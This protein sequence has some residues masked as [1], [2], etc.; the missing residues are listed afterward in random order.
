M[1]GKLDR[2]ALPAPDYGVLAGE[3][4]AP[5]SVA[6]EILCG[7]FADVLGLDVV[8]PEGDFFELGGHSLLAVRLA[9]R[10][11]VLLGVEIPVR[12]VFAAPTPAGLAAWLAQAAPARLRL[13]P[14]GRP[15]RVPLSFAQQ[16]LWFIAQLEGPSA[17]YNNPVALRLEGDLDAA[18]LEAALGD[19]LAR[20]EVLRTVFPSDHGDPFQ[21]VLDLA[22]L[23]WALPVTEVAEEELAGMI[24]E[25]A[26]VPFDLTTEVPVRLRLLA[27]GPGVHVL[28]VVIHH[29]ATDGWSTG[30]LARDIST[31]Y[32]ARL[33]GREPDW[34]PLPVQYA[35]YAI[36]QR[37]LL[38][39]EDDPASLLA[40]QV[41]WWRHA[42]DGAPPELALPADHPRPPMPS[43]RGH[44]VPLAIPAEVHARLAELDSRAGRDDV[45]G[46]PGRPRG[47]AV[48]ARGG[49][50][51]PVGTAVAG[52]ADEAVDDLVGFFVNTLVLRT[53]VSGDP[54]FTDV[55]ARVREYWLAAL[56]HQDVPFERLVEALA[57]ERSLARHALFQVMLTVQNNTSAAIALPGQRAARMPTGKPTARFDLQVSLG[58]AR[59]DQGLPAGL[60]G[61][62]VAAADLFDEATARAL[63]GRFAAVLAAVTASPRIPL[64]E[65]AVLAVA[66]R[67]QLLAGWNDTA[68]GVPAGSL[69]GLILDRAAAAPDAVAVVCG[70][71]S[72][73]YGE[74][75]A[76][77]SRL[78]WLLR[79]RGAGPESVVGVCLERGPGMVA[80]VV[81]AWLAGAGYVPLDP[82]YPAER[83]AFMLADSGAGLVVTSGSVAGGL[84]AVSAGVVCLDDPVT[85]AELAGLPSVPPPGE[86]DAGQLA[87]VIYTSGSTGRPNGVAVGQGS[88]VNMAAALSPALDARP[89]SRML[90]FAS[91]SFDAS[92]L[93]VA[94]SLTSGCTLVI[95]SAAERSDPAVLAGLVEQT[96]MPD[97]E[98]GA[99]AAGGHGPG[100]DGSGRE[101]DRGVGAAAGAAGGGVVGGTAADSRLR[102]DRGD[103]DHGHG[104][105]GRRWRSAADRDADGQLAGVRAGPVAGAGPGGGGRGAVPG[106]GAAGPGL[107]GPAGAD[108]VE[109]RGLPV[110]GRGADVPDG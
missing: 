53:D 7:A 1:N 76:R 43:H 110:R 49:E 54:A 71:G 23:G 81:A 9:S 83:L 98:R 74:L 109:V 16:R 5:Q 35:D 14:Q 80:A 87:Y 33:Q 88:V 89:G 11:R 18:A 29:V 103:G 51:I 42:L 26:A 25:T 102:A 13:V 106:R 47:P 21:H 97:R 72:V 60:G 39:D 58:E 17:V 101:H 56:D 91:F 44:V 92:V 46:H 82:G 48:Q 105:D 6:E 32:A 93:D 64:R 70:C 104:A 22:E 67:V 45:H 84:G 40:A 24:A 108:R 96:G 52:R 31:A 8:G 75:V 3:A 90:Q 20:H 100:P 41:A 77:A 50:D 73:S 62:L 19:V 55:L 10:V 65:V 36:W 34:A 37:D 107:R 95:A 2:R 79:G 78:A 61:S 68:R 38:G 86:P 28:V 15:E 27:A 12:A 85:L 94:V 69:A 59:D 99:V 57:P 66:E 4:R 30:V 63:G